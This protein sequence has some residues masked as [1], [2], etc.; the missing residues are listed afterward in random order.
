MA[1]LA[2]CGRECIGDVL[3]WY[4]DDEPAPTELGYSPLALDELAGIVRG[5]PE[6][7][8]ENASSRLSLAGTQNKIGLAH[9][10]NLDFEHGWLRPKG[11]AATTHLLKTS[12]LRDLSEIEYLCMSAAAGCG[13]AV[14]RTHLLALPTP[15]LA[16]ERFDRNANVVGGV[17]RVERRH[18]ED[19][20]QALSL[21]PGSKYAEL[22]GGSAASI[23]R[24]IR[25]KSVRP[26]RDLAQFARTLLFCYAIGNCDAHLKNYSIILEASKRDGEPLIALTPV[27]DLVST[28]RYPRFSRELA[29]AI[30]GVRAIDDVDPAALTNLAN[31]L[32]ITKAALQKIARDI[33]DNA[34]GAIGAAGDGAYGPVFDSTSY[35]ADD[36]VEEMG[37]RLEVLDTFCIG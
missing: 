27:Y 22:P 16:V 6:S 36:L 21:T 35:V 24:L 11:L 4:T 25:S 26:A 1:I 9:N 10:P 3:V 29:M 33:L 19:L 7:S 13:I 31:D 2:H 34:A 17:L 18:Q 32:G 23:A 8:A 28:T 15:T 37:P 5:L 12:Y 20:A 14:A 30:G